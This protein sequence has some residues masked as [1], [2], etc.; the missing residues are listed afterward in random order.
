MSSIDD[1]FDT[2]WLVCVMLY[3]D[4]EVELA[5]VTWQLRGEGVKG[6]FEW[7]YKKM[8]KLRP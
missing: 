4:E 8:V 6:N 2:A 7:K 1:I 5:V 3:V